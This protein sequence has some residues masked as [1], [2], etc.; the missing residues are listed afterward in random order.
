L[1]VT[2]ALVV[3]AIGGTTHD[4]AASGGLPCPLYATTGVP[5]PLCGMT[6]ATMSLGAGDLGAAFGAHPVFPLVLAFVL[7]GG[8]R[9]A[10]GRALSIKGRPITVVHVL[11]GTSIVWAINVVGHALG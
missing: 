11:I 2:G 9:L 6:R 8:A 5:C 10:L 4:H 3:G 1:G 7:W